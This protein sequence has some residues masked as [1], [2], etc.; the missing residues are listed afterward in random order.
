MHYEIVVTEGDQQ[1]TRPGE[2]FPTPIRVTVWMDYTPREFEAVRFRLT[3]ALADPELTT[4]TFGDG[5]ATVDTLTG[6]DA[7]ATVTV[8]AG[9]ATGPV[10]LTITATPDGTPIRAQVRLT[11]LPNGISVIGCGP[12]DR[13]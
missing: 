10:N 2:P 9:T 12:P 1:A 13:R 5:S 3:Q 8:Q 11:V 4:A 7:A 6:A